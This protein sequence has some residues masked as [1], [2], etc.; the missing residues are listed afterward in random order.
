MANDHVDLPKV[1]STRQQLFVE[2]KQSHL[3]QDDLAAHMHGE[4]REVQQHL[5]CRQVL[6]HDVLPVHGDDGDAQEEVEVVRLVVRPAGL[7]HA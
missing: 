5:V 3:P 4:A 2:A 6:L 7:P 1:P